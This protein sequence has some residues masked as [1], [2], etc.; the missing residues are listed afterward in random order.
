MLLA[1]TER[2]VESE[3]NRGTFTLPVHSPAFSQKTLPIFPP[4]LAVAN[5]GSRVGPHNKIGHP[6]GGRF[7]C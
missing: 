7:P 1:A 6:A 3:Q 4:V 2:V 5:T